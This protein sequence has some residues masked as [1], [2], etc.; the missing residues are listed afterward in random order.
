MRVNDAIT[1]AAFL[2]LAVAIYFHAGTFRAMPGVPYGPDLFPRLVAFAM[3]IGALFLIGG[4]LFP[5]NRQPLL[6]LAPWA[7]KPRSYVL[8]AAVVGCML[9]YIFFSVALGFLLSCFLALGGLLLVTR[10][11]RHTVSS[12][13]IAAL[14]TGATY[15]LFARSL[16]VPLP[17]GL[18][19]S[20]LVS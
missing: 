13:M 3:G 11:L 2:A 9:F 1:G 19:E 20:L 17:Y 15:L 12:V 16:R 14:V 18:I 8:F 4:A 7:L 10:G 6:R 5:A